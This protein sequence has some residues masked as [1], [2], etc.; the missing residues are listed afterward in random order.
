MGDRNA[1]R[2]DTSV[3][4]GAHT[5]VSPQA[6]PRGLARLSRLGTSTSLSMGPA[7]AA[8]PAQSTETAAPP[9]ALEISAATPSVVETRALETGA[10]HRGSQISYDD[11]PTNKHAALAPDDPPQPVALAPLE[12]QSVRKAADSLHDDEAP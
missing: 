10:A 7:P 12:V 5:S 1:P 8:A 9:S 2:H 11:L 6:A 3:R 4:R